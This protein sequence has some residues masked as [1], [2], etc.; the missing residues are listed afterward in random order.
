LSPTSGYPCTVEFE[1]FKDGNSSLISA[2]DFD[3]HSC[4]VARHVFA[5]DGKAIEHSIRH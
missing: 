2:P 5:F 3:C 1:I 4:D